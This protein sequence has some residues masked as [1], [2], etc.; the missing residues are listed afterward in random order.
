M[1]D[2]KS[3]QYRIQSEQAA[4]SI[5]MDWPEWQR[6]N[7]GDPRKP[8]NRVPE[9]HLK[10]AVEVVLDVARRY[11]APGKSPHTPN[12]H[13]CEVCESMRRVIEWLATDRIPPVD[14]A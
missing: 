12:G 14:M 13:D 9:D 6:R 5:F 2:A 4:R 1:T 10:Y 11:R 3:D 8:E 7:A